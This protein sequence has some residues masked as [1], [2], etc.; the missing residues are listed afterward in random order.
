MK[1]IM[2]EKERSE[3]SHGERQDKLKKALKK[4][5][6]SLGNATK[7]KVRRGKENGERATTIS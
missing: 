6:T 1:G 7:Q 4:T 3:E 2:R 5:F